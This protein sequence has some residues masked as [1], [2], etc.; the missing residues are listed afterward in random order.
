M[1]TAM[2]FAE[3]R[4]FGRREINIRGVAIAPGH[5]SQPFTIRNI[6]DGG[7]LLVFDE[8][9]TPPRSFRI[10]IA[11]TEFVLLCEA[12]HHS[13]NAVGVSFLRAAEGIALN[14]HFQ[15]RTVDGL[16][17]GPAPVTPRAAPH[18]ATVS[19]RE[20]RQAIRHACVPPKP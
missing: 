13:G 16:T 4:R 19:G 15:L 3:Q 10:E 12:R 8:A 14:R 7:A 2:A 1:S 11:G 9:H 20:L 6:S 5:L 17:G 18:V